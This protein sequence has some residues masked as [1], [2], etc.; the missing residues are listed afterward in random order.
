MFNRLTTLHAGPLPHPGE[1]G[2]GDFFVVSGAANLYVAYNFPENFWVNF[3]L[4]GLLGLT[5]VFVLAQAAW[6]ARRDD[7]TKPE[8]TQGK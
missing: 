8:S 4:F 7:G 3:K 1:D 5:I 6:L 2:F